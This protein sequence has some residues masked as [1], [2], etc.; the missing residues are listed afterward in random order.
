[1]NSLVVYLIKT[2]SH[3][4]GSLR[5]KTT[6]KKN[7]KFTEKQLLGLAST[8]TLFASATPVA[9]KKGLTLEGLTLYYY[10]A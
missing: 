10:V 9:T 6:W 3:L 2:D 5:N 1:M 8:A 4:K 7:T